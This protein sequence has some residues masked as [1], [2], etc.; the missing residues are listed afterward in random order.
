[1]SDWGIKSK[2][3]IALLSD[4]D[5]RQAM[6]EVASWEAERRAPY[7]GGKLLQIAKRL[8][9]EVGVSSDYEDYTEEAMLLMP[10]WRRQVCLRWAEEKVIEEAARRFAAMA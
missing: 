2:A 4:A 1:M 5:L 6:R 8:A 9:D 3:L 7:D 10:P